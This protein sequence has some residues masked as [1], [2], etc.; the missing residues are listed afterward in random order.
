M[1]R[2][3][4][5]VVVGTAF[6]YISLG[7]IGYAAFGNDVPGNVLSGFYEPF[8][9]VDMANIA[10]IIH[11]IGAYQVYPCSIPPSHVYVLTLACKTTT[12]IG[13]C[14]YDASHLVEIQ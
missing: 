7:C 5:Y 12:R 14:S 13:L 8:W 9:L 1:K 6:F 2:V 10:V 4:L 11:L 3:S